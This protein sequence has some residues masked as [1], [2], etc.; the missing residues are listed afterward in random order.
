MS[1]DLWD[2]YRQMYRGRVLEGAVD[3]LWQQGLI[4]GEMHLGA[5]EEAIAAGVV[6]QLGD[7]DA[8]ALDHR[9]TL[10]LL[11]RGID[12]VLLVRE[13]LGRQGGL[14]R[15]AGGHMHLFAKDLLAASSGIVGS[16]GPVAAGFALAATY[17]R[18]GTIAIAFFGDGAANQ[19]MLLEAMNLAVAWTLPLVFVCKDNAWAISTLSGFRH[20]REPGRPCQRVWH[21]GTGHRRDGRGSCVACR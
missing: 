17:L 10:P 8:M 14:C 3:A 21:G 20:R 7:G 5:G 18:P 13:F 16:A 19:G 1:A 9:G 6:S 15:G 11:M 12:P 2:L 4:S